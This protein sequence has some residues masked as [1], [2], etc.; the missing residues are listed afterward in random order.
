MKILLDTHIFLWAITGD[1]RLREVSRRLFESADNELLLGSPS[2][3]EI[4]VKQRLGKLALPEPS[5]AYLRRQLQRNRIEILALA[6]GH[7]FQLETLAPL[8]RDPFDRM[9]VAQALG[10]GVPLLTQDEQIRKYPV[11]CLG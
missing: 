6:A 8:H 3:W 2:L 5:S 7:V 4:L 1:A 9:L 10:E 11:E